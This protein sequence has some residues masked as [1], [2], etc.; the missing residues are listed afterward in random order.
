MNIIVSLAFTLLSGLLLT[1]AFKYLHLSFP[2]VTVYLLTGLLLGPYCLGKL[3][4]TGI[5]FSDFG[6]LRSLSLINEVALGFIAFSIGAEF[7]LDKIAKSGKAT[8]IIGV[9][10]ALTASLLVDVSLLVLRTFVGGE[11]LTI[12]VCITLG[13]IASATAPAATLMVVRQ[14]GAKGPLTDLLLP[15][16]A[17]DDA[18]GLIIFAVSLGVAQ[19]FNGG[20]L[21]FA[22]VFVD[23]LLEI[24]CS[25]VLGSLLG[26]VMSKLEKLFYSPDHRMAM[27][28]AFI[29]LAIGLSS[30]S[31]DLG[32][33]RIGFSSLLVLMMLGTVFC[34]IS[35]F[36]EDIFERADHW[37]APLY[38]AFFILS[39]AQLDLAVLKNPMILAIG[40]LYILMR[41]SG[42]YAGSAL[43]AKMLGLHQNIVKY[44]GITLFPQAGV[45][46]GMVNTAQVLGEGNGTTIRNVAL[47]SVMI[48][49]L[50]GPSLT[51]TAL[52]KAGE[53]RIHEEKQHR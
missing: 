19:A 45:A 21:S 43:P 48:Y 24:L 18:V 17:L 9:L 1:R 10:Q 42:K 13:A 39:G 29:L 36:S 44:L 50:V 16:V 22:A 27:T 41:C 6:Q 52:A 3:G 11:V 26:T 28:I 40:A 25:V 47:L 7:K 20:T 46:L 4:L 32:S 49:E 33:I 37:T 23:P 8:L 15:I 35:E 2:D 51:K 12:P 38:V 53:I 30:L 5:G 31:F 34:N 14:Y